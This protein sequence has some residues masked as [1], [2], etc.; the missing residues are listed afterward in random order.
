[1]SDSNY[2]RNICTKNYC[3]A[4]LNSIQELIPKSKEEIALET[5]LPITT[6]IDVLEFMTDIGLPLIRAGENIV[7]LY[8]RI[9][10]LNIVYIRKIVSDYDR[11]V[12]NLIEVYDTVD[13]DQRILA[14]SL[15]L[16]V[17]SQAC[18]HCGTHV[19]WAR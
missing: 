3:T 8:R 4:I 16:T 19:M 14:G 18:M 9:M 11:S 7:R 10:P 15:W 2:A 5:G 6:V 12:S 1:M 13:S 17:D